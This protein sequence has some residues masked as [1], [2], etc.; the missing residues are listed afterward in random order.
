MAYAGARKVYAY[1]AKQKT[2]FSVILEDLGLRFASSC[3]STLAHP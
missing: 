3:T 1:S 2:G